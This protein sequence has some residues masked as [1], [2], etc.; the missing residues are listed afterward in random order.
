M[1]NV[2]HL[3]DLVLDGEA[4]AVPSR[5]TFD[6]FTGHGS[7]ACDYVFNCSGEDVAIVGQAGG[8][9]RSV[10]E[11]VLLVESMD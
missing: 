4:V 7:V 10:V 5:A 6:R 11:G 1:C 2:E 9:W 8:E 3:I